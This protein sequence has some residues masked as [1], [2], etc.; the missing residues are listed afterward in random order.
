MRWPMAGY[1]P[2]SNR[3]MPVCSWYEGTRWHNQ[4][5]DTLYQNTLG[6]AGWPTANRAIYLPFLLEEPMLITE[7]TIS[8]GAGASA[9]SWDLGVYSADGVRLVSSGLVAQAGGANALQTIPLVDTLLDRGVFYM[10]L[11]A[12]STSTTVN[13]YQG[14][15]TV[16]WYVWGALQQD[17]ASP[18]PAIATFASNITTFLPTFTLHSRP[19]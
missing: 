10:A 3:L 18:L 1:S 17:S 2:N 8:N 12:T 16:D 13:R 6:S 19:I 15:I 7:A 11:V 9:G 4:G 14:G 5:S